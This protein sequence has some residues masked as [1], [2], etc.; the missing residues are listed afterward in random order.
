M[1]S[2]TMSPVMVLRPVAATWSANSS[3]WW[4]GICG[5]GAGFGAVFGGEVGEL[6]GGE[7][8]VGG[9]LEDEVAGEGRS[10]DECRGR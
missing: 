6:A 5:G 2:P 8:G 9:S 10:S 7:V 1:S 4:R 3:R